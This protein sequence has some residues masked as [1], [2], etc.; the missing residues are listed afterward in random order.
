MSKINPDLVIIG[1]ENYLSENLAG[2]LRKLN[3]NVF[4]PDDHGAK[5]ESSKEFMKEFCKS[6]KYQPLAQ[7][8]LLPLSLL[9]LI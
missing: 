7:R 8:H 2:K 3:F 9:K 6:H 4:G 1:P 5:L